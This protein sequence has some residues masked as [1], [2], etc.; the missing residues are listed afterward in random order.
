MLLVRIIQKVFLLKNLSMLNCISTVCMVKIR[1]I[2]STVE[3]LRWINNN[4]NKYGVM[5]KKKEEV[6]EEAL[7]ILQDY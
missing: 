2:S 3:L 1:S 5:S 7:E 6:Q 4:V